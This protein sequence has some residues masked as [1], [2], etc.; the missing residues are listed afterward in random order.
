[1]DKREILEN[2]IR[3]A[4]ESSEE[5]KKFVLELPSEEQVWLDNTLK[6]AFDMQTVYYDLKTIEEKKHTF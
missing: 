1:M 6:K 5:A 2:Y 3:L 4:T